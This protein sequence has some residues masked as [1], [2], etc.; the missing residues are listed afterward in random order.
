[1]IGEHQALDHVA[2]EAEDRLLVAAQGVPE[3]EDDHKHPEEQG[4]DQERH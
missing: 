4:Q 2:D 1:M 3:A